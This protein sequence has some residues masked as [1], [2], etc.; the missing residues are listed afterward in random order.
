MKT[1]VEEEE[2]RR[3]KLGYSKLNDRT[4]QNLR[5]S[6]ALREDFEGNMNSER[7]EH[8]IDKTIFNIHSYDQLANPKYQDDYQYV[9]VHLRRNTKQSKNR[10]ADYN[11]TRKMID[12]AYWYDPSKNQNLKEE[13]KSYY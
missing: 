6:L 4:Y 12:L 7:R 5:Y 9:P 2:Y 13:N 11:F 1:M 3:D 8:L 10:R